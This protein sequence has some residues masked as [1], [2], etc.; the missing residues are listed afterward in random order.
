[1]SFHLIF[2]LFLFKIIL[3][4]RKFHN[5]FEDEVMKSSK[6]SHSFKSF[7]DLEILVKKSL[8]PLAVMGSEEG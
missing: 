3:V 5:A 6:S 8:Y 2:R 7:R 4:S 1:V